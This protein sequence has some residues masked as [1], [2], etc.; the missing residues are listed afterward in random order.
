MRQFEHK[1]FSKS[2][3]S[4]FLAAIFLAMMLSPISHA[5]VNVSTKFVVTYNGERT[6]YSPGSQV[7]LYAPA[8][9]NSELFAG[10]DYD[11]DLIT[12]PGFYYNNGNG[13]IMTFRMP[14][15][16]VE[17]RSTYGAEW[18]VT[19]DGNTGVETSATSRIINGYSY[20][21][22]YMLSE[23]Q[24]GYNVN[25][26]PGT[27]VVST[28]D[29]SSLIRAQIN[30][31]MKTYAA[32]QPIVITQAFADNS[33]GDVLTG[34]TVD[35][36]F[37]KGETY[38]YTSLS[39]GALYR[40]TV[41]PGYSTD[42]TINAVY[43][44]GCRVSIMDNI[45]NSFGYELVEKG[46]DVVFALPTSQG[47]YKLHNVTATDA[48]GSDV[49]VQQT[50]QTD[51]NTILRLTA[52]TSRVDVNFSWR[53][54]T[55]VPEPEGNTTPVQRTS[56]AKLSEHINSTG[57]VEAYNPTSINTLT[58]DIHIDAD[59]IQRNRDEIIMLQK[60]LSNANG[61]IDDGNPEAVYFFHDP[62]ITLED[63]TTQK[64]SGWYLQKGSDIPKAND[65]W[66]QIG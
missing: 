4:M 66:Q 62:E 11:P 40:H 30:G 50:A 26:M 32:G 58:P 56:S 2:I 3:L 21:D 12:A 52:V 35:G 8:I 31:S 61:T 37:E 57:L 1:F 59:D 46:T 15:C 49:E 65:T 34:Y 54:A 17:I 14:S 33:T 16:P 25:L 41:F 64:L 29:N 42:V 19:Q 63:G 28:Y 10:F 45:G 5:T 6:P 36:S 24:S 51:G 44:E 22:H 7:K 48:N 27:A 55:E 20:I 9:Q 39:N 43:E 38:L 23:D 13:Y 47:D 53:E 60:M 18:T